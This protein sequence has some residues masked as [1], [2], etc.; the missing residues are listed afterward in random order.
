M[1]LSV[2]IFWNTATTVVTRVVKASTPPAL[3]FHLKK[4]GE[5]MQ[6]MER[7]TYDACTSMEQV[8]ASLGLRTK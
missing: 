7:A 3:D 1:T 8:A 2:G 6:Q 5:S 4:S